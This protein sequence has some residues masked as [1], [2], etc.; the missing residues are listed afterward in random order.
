M[1]RST[2][3]LIHDVR[4]P[5]NTISINAELGKL[6]LLKNGDINKAIQIFETILTECQL[7]SRRI[8]E[9]KESLQDD[10][11]A[12]AILKEDRNS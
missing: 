10:E 3:A 9:L 12:E 7:C 1:K 5:L 8:T 4:N 2:S 11:P 6:T